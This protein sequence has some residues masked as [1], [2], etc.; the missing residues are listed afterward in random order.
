MNLILAKLQLAWNDGRPWQL[1]LDDFSLQLQ[2][3]LMLSQLFLAILSLDLLCID[4]HILILFLFLFRDVELDNILR[5]F[6]ILEETF[7]LL[8]ILLPLVQWSLHMLAD[9]AI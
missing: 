4:D 2:S 9:N 3:L 5:L 7:H 8:V 6:E 1:S